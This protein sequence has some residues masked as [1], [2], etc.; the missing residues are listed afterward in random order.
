MS[1]SASP[2][3]QPN[4]NLNLQK[5]CEIPDENLEAF[6][7]LLQWMFGSVLPIPA[8][9]DSIWIVPE[10]ELGTYVNRIITAVAPDASPHEFG[11]YTPGGVAVPVETE[12]GAK[13]FVLLDKSEIVHLSPTNYFLPDVISTIL[14]EVLHVQLYSLAWQRRGFIQYRDQEVGCKIDYYNLCSNF[15]D[16]YAVCRLKAQMLKENLLF[17][18]EQGEIKPVEFFYGAPLD[19]SINRAVADLKQTIFGAA[20]ASIP[21]ESAW[22]KALNQI[23]RGILEPLARNAGFVAANPDADHPYNNANNSSFYVNYFSRYWH[24]IEQ[25]LNISFD[26]D[27]SEEETALDHMVEHLDTF[28]KEIGVSLRQLDSSDC[29]VDFTTSFFDEMNL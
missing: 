12:V 14:E 1:D 4:R 28:L 22:P 27:F 18:T 11:T 9:L 19:K 2:N 10:G 8:L 21:I 13:A 23:Y 25:Q 26:S 16:E 20:S 3:L 6:V 7:S 17:K 15:H 29:W 24:L 5:F